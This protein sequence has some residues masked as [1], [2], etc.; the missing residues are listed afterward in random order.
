MKFT[1]MFVS[2]SETGQRPEKLS[3]KLRIF[4]ET[5]E[6]SS[7]HHEYSEKT[8]LLPDGGKVHHRQVST[9]TLSS[10]SVLSV[11]VADIKPR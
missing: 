2:L 10:C 5:A 3:R 9:V 4:K 6:S 8:S 1:V 7:G 11:S